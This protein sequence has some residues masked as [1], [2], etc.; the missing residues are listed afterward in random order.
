M[1]S[2]RLRKI[3]MGIAALAALGLGGATLANAVDG[4]GGAATEQADRA[5]AP[6]T[7]DDSADTD[8]VQDENGPG[9]TSDSGDAAPLTGAAAD[10]AKQVAL[11]E[12]GG[13]T[14]NHVE[15]DE[16]KGATYEVEVTKPDGSKVDV[17]IDAQFRVIAVDSDDGE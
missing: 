3:L 14:V 6:E 4:G 17:R 7:A 11:Q 8:D 1:V 12:T 10:R 9:D 5:D 16:E 2:D 13:G 15:A